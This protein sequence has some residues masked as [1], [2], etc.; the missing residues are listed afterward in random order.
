MPRREILYY[1]YQN[2]ELRDYFDTLPVEIKNKI[3]DSGVE[4]AT[5]GEL[6]QCAAHFEMQQE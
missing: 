2:A 6:K 1:Y 5:L 3:M 4:I